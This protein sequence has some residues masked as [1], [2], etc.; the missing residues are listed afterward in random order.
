MTTLS[1]GPTRM[2]T[3]MLTRREPIPRTIAQM[4]SERRLKTDTDVWILTTMVGSDDADAY[5]LDA[6]KHSETER[7]LG[8][9]LLYLGLPLLLIG[10]G[11]LLFFGRK[12]FLAPS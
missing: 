11:V 2:V 4:N 5:P 9:M 12:R 8:A 3:V 10:V 6:S 1:F 7:E